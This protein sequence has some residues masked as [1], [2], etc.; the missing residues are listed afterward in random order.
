MALLIG[1]LISI[2]VHKKSAMGRDVYLA[3][4]AH[5]Y[6]TTMTHTHSP[7]VQTIGYGIFIAFILGIYELLAFALQY[8]FT[9]KAS[10]PG[11]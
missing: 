6:D 10:T 11:N 2:D 7:V 3:S 4:Q 5:Y 8:L 9:H 1:K